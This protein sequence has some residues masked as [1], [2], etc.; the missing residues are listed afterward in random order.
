MATNYT[1]HGTGS[2]SGTEPHGANSPQSI[3][4]TGAGNTYTSMPIQAYPQANHPTSHMSSAPDL[5]TIAAVTQ[6][7]TSVGSYSYPAICHPQSAHAMAA[8]APRPA[9][10]MHPLGN[11]GPHTGAPGNGACYSYLD[12]VYS[13]P[14]PAHGH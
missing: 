5:R 4:D 1:S 13:M 8:S 10:D 12:P 11:G 6:P 14:D 7:Y 9:W 3:S 2:D